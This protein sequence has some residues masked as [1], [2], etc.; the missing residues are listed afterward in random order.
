VTLE[1]AVLSD[2]V[3]DQG[4]TAKFEI[5]SRVSNPPV[6]ARQ[7]AEGN[8]LVASLSPR[9][10]LHAQTSGDLHFIAPRDSCPRKV[11]ALETAE[12]VYDHRSNRLQL[13]FHVG[14]Q[15]REEGEYRSGQRWKAALG[16]FDQK[17]KALGKLVT[18]DAKLRERAFIPSQDVV[19]RL[20]RS[21]ESM[22]RPGTGAHSPFEFRDLEHNPKKISTAAGRPENRACLS[23]PAEVSN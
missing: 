21:Q 6:G 23:E 8:A 3:C 17:R 15:A 2:Q 14:P 7:P 11:C 5:P 16:R 1:E 20:R 4:R 12:P 9:A 10:I 22:V 19:E 18:C 13:F